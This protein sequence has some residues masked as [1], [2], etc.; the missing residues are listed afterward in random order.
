M[1]RPWL[2]Y[3]VL[4]GGVLVVSTAS[5]LIRLAQAEGMPSLTIAAMRMGLAALILLPIAAP[6]LRRDLPRD[7]RQETG[8]HL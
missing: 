6:R 5:I 3:A 8:G 2:P 1:N 7:P 4:A